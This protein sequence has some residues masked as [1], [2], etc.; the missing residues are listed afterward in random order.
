MSYSAGHLALSSVGEAVK[1]WNVI[2]TWLREI[3]VLAL[4]QFISLVVWSYL[5]HMAG[6]SIPSWLRWKIIHWSIPSCEPHW[7]SL[8][9]IIFVWRFQKRNEI[10]SCGRYFRVAR[11]ALTINVGQISPN[12]NIRS[13]FTFTFLEMESFV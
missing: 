5:V 8:L 12:N 2:N 13:S 10:H 6:H 1:V 9:Y 7:I 11:A 3:Q 4:Y